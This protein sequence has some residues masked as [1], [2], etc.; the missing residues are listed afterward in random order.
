VQRLSRHPQRVAGRQLTFRVP[1][2][3]T[4]PPLISLSGHSPIHEANAEALRNFVKLG[5]I[6]P[7]RVCAIPVRIQE[8]GSD[9]PRRCALVRYT[10]HLR[11]QPAFGAVG[12][13][14]PPS[15]AQER[16]SQGNAT[17]TGKRLTPHCL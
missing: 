11:W 13:P 17:E 15:P 8:F 4:L 5:P 6:S 1:T 7:N 2:Q 9:Q 3:R 14:G 12:E 16:M 10:T